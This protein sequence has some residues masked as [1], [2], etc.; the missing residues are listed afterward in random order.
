LLSGKLKEYVVKSGCFLILYNTCRGHIWFRC[1][2]VWNPL[3]EWI[4]G[5]WYWCW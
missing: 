4:V 3:H 1:W 2:N 5:I